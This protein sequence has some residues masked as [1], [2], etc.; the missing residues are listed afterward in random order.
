MNGLTPGDV[1][2][3]WRCRIRCWL[4]ARAVSEQRREPSDGTDEMVLGRPSAALSPYVDRYI[5]YRQERLSSGRH[6]GLPSRHMTL[7]ISL[8]DPVT[9][10]TMPGLPGSAHTFPGLISGLHAGPVTIAADRLQF[11]IHVDLTPWAAGALLGHPAGV[12]A[13]GVYGITSVLGVRGSELLERV[14]EAADWASRF[15]A[16]DLVLG[17]AQ[18]SGVWT[19]QPEV[20]QAWTA[21]LRTGGRIPVHQL[22][23]H[24]GWS[25]RYLSER[26]R[27]ELGLAP[28]TAG[29]VIRFDRSHTALTRQGRP[30]L[31]QIA[32][33]CGYAD[34]A[35]LTR[36]W[37]ELAGQ[38]PSAWMAA[39]LRGG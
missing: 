22:A 7:I 1:P 25:R 20:T 19:A 2:V 37:R 23:R 6:Q 17:R 30:G 10:L 39:E 26:F 32:A 36:E 27:R 21:L 3:C 11:G 18:A 12:L 9:V 38:T 34:Q 13:G 14:R 15:A 31:A 24:V 16:I 35:H 8:A 5:G 33:D 28:K 29:R 4:Y